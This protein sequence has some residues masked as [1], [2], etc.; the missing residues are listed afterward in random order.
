MK[1]RTTGA[2]VSWIPGTST[3]LTASEVPGTGAAI[4]TRGTTTEHGHIRHGDTIRGTTIHGIQDS[5]ILTTITCTHT[6][7]D[8]MVAGDHT[9]EESTIGHITEAD[10]L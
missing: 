8:G 7:A 5:M 1:I 4:G 6:I 9:L 10:T 2:T 3:H